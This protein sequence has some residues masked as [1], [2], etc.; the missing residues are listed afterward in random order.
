MVQRKAPW[1]GQKTGVQHLWEAWPEAR[2][3]VALGLDFLFCK[4]GVMSLPI[5]Q[6]F[7]E[8][9]LAGE[10][11]DALWMS[12]TVHMRRGCMVTGSVIAVN[13][14]WCFTCPGAEQHRKICWVPVVS[15]GDDNFFSG[16]QL[17]FS[18]TWLSQESVHLDTEFECGNPQ[19]NHGVGGSTFP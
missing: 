13:V 12:N 9:K 15:T 16:W 2:F 3:W 19:S 18:V 1:L 6:G 5:S 7:G 4:M 10:C 14:T 8:D 11:E 17:V